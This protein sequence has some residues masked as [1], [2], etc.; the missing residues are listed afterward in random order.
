[1]SI[2]F[3]KTLKKLSQLFFKNNYELY[4]VGGAV[5]DILMDKTPHDYDFATNATPDQMLKIAEES[6]IEVIPTGIKYG[7][8]TFRIDNQSFECTS[9]RSDG[10][11]SDGRRPDQVTFS[12]NILDDLSRRD[13][14]VNAIALNMLSNVNDYVDPFNGIKDIEDKVIRTVGDPV[15]R[16]TEDGLRILRAIR[17]RFKLWFTF[18]TATYKAIMSNWQLLEHISQERIT[19]EFLQILTYGHL[20]SAEDCYLMDALIKQILPEAYIENVYD[21]N[22]WEYKTLFEFPDIETKLAFILKNSKTDVLDLCY[23]LKLSNKMSRDI[24]ET[25]YCK[26]LFEEMLSSNDTSY[27]VRKLVSKCGKENAKRGFYLYDEI[28]NLTEKEWN[29]LIALLDH[30]DTEAIKLS[31]LKITGDDL[32]QLGFKG[33]EIGKALDYCLDRVLRNQ[34]LNEKEKL[35]GLVKHYNMKEVIEEYAEV[36]GDIKLIKQKVMVK[37]V[38]SDITAVKIIT[39]NTKEAKKLSDD[40][41]EEEKQ[42]LLKILKD[43]EK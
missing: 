30:S 22:W 23:K 26:S 38:L 7:T 41:L 24:V 21:C 3:I 32:I 35:I 25:I 19:S 42:K 39:D 29:Y 43:K 2:D 12:T 28:Y 37:N 20:D 8:V 6:N 15:E 1:M 10:N 18:D 13:F 16:F 34:S 9:Y 33:R 5:R 36:D 27:I 31:D 17:F 40:E 14:T 11:Y 4:M